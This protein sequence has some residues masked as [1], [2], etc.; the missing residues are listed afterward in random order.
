ADFQLTD[1]NGKPFHLGSLHGRPVVVFF[2]FAHCPDVCPAVLHN[3]AMLK[4]SSP[5]SLREVSVVMISVDGERDTPE[6][7][8]AYLRSFSPDFIGLTGT[9][10]DVHIIAARFSATFFKDPPK[11]ASGAY[12]V[13]HTSRVYA[14]DRK[15]RLRAE[16]YD[17][18]PQATAGVLHALVAER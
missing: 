7:M 4:K 13:Q 8:R 6:V 5:E 15:G 11:D 18:S 3:L 1:Q 9:S 17:A 12:L 14:L 10:A 2:G 16:M